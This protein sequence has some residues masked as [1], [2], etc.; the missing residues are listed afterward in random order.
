[1]FAAAGYKGDYYWTILESDPEWNDFN[2]CDPASAN[3]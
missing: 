2:A 1:L 3:H